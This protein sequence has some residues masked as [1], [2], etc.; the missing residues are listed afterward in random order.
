MRA[1]AQGRRAFRFMKGAV[2][3]FAHGAR[4]LQN[5]FTICP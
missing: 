2:T 3:A 4:G 1:L 5:L